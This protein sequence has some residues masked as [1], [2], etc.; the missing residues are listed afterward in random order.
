MK[1][2][3][4]SREIWVR[5]TR[6]QRIRMCCNQIIC[7]SSQDRE[8]SNHS[9]KNKQNW[10]HSI[11]KSDMS[12]RCRILYLSMQIS[13]RNHSTCNNILFLLYKNKISDNKL[14]HKSSKYQKSYQQLREDVQTN[15]MIHSAADSITVQS[16]WETA[17]WK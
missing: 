11:L 16:D 12:I 6:N 13:K 5:A 14:M 8:Y 17:V 7:S 15:Q 10:A 4:R 1:M 3:I 9:N 2:M